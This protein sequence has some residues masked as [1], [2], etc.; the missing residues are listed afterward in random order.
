MIS[1]YNLASRDYGGESDP[2]LKLTIGHKV[3]NDRENY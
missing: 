3:F 1:G 2:F